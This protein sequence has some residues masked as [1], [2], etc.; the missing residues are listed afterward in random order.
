MFAEKTACL[1]DISLVENTET[2][3][4]DDIVTV[5]LTL[6]AECSKQKFESVIGGHASKIVKQNEAFN[7]L[8]QV[9]LLKSLSKNKMQQLIEKLEVKKYQNG[10]Q[11]VC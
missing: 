3:Y 2:V 7:V 10:I 4:D 9:A 1:G 5:G 11:I 6:I 8:K